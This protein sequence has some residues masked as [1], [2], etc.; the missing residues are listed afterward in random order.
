MLRIG[1]AKGATGWT[2]TL[3]GKLAGPWVDELES[4][5]NATGHEWQ[6][7]AVVLDL[8]GVTYVDCQGKKLLCWLYEEGVNLQAHDVLNKALIQEIQAKHSR[9][10]EVF[11]WLHSA[12][13]RSHAK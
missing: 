9:A 12:A 13:K 11:S 4:T 10:R 2:V 6:G 7:Q 5:W 3:E 8:S 1:V